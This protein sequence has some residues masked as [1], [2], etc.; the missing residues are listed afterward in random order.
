ME[1]ALGPSANNVG[2]VELFSVSLCSS[3]VANE[4]FSK[5]V[6]S[7]RLRHRSARSEEATQL[8]LLNILLFH[9]SLSIIPQFCSLGTSNVSLIGEVISPD[10]ERV[11]I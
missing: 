7:H 2:W 9:N 3:N 10:Y 8:N 11:F 4:L 1:G 5:A 6:N